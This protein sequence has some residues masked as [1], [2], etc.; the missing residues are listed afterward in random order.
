M[1]VRQKEGQIQ[2]TDSE[3][4]RNTPKTDLQT[5]RKKL[6]DTETERKIPK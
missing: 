3:G 6:R 2:T 1:G 4:E 5:D